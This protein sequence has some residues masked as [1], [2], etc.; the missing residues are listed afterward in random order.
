M[1][2]AN[3]FADVRDNTVV[4]EDI[5]LSCYRPGSQSVHGKVT[6]S[7]DETAPDALVLESRGGVELARSGSHTFSVSCPSLSISETLLHAPYQTIDVNKTQGLVRR[8]SAFDASPDRHLIATGHF[9]GAVTLLSTAMTSLVPI[10]ATKNLHMSTVLS[11]R[12]F[13]SSKVLLS[14]SSDFSLNIIS[15]ATPSGENDLPLLAVPRVLKGHKSGV[16]DTAILGVGRNVLSCS[17]DGTIRLWDV[18]EARKIGSSLASEGFKPIIKIGLGTRRG[19]DCF[20]QMASHER[21]TPG[22]TSAADDNSPG[23]VIYA[24]LNDGSFNVFDLR[25]RNAIY[26]SPKS[27]GSDS[28]R[29][30]LTAIAYDARSHILATG[31]Q[32]GIITL[33]DARFLPA[34]STSSGPLSSLSPAILLSFQRSNASID[35]LL[36]V[37]PTAYSAIETHPHL[38]V[39][40]AD[41]FPF[42]A[43][44]HPNGPRVVEEYV[45]FADEGVRVVRM[46]QRDGNN[47]LGDVWCVG[48]DGIVRRY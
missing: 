32:K 30:G 11:L 41:G 24:A 4:A 39:A 7:K 47:V 33:F 40:P 48:D 44:V 17:K 12:F 45:G 26:A 42:R 15:T 25:A 6:V 9:D 18:G 16:T 34:S 28:S 14:A 46:T 10:N 35:D 38:L 8:I 31:S 20:H 27:I 29:S 22:P 2:F 13:P 37:P 1:T 21:R 3:V 36:F 43:S 19:L 5:Y 23:N